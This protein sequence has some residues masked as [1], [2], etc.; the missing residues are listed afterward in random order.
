[1]NRILLIEDEAQLSENI[2]EL[3]ELTGYDVQVTD[4]AEQGVEMLFQ[5]PPDLILCDVS[6]PDREGYYVLEQLNAS[7]L[8]IPFIFV[9]AR[10]D[11]Q[12]IRRSME[13]GADDY[14]MKPFNTPDLLA[15]VKARLLKYG[16]IRRIL[17]GE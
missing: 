3:L 12:D 9:S 2:A 1:M 7:S 13:L 10:V 4:R 15:A 16:R 17:L 14:I 5:N 8:V 6:L 11:T